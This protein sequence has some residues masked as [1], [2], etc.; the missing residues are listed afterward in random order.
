M[1]I[2][3]YLGCQA[4]HRYNCSPDYSRTIFA[5]DSLQ[6]E[7]AEYSRHTDGKLIRQLISHIS[8][9]HLLGGAI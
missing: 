4:V 6:G 7:K 1:T 3:V 8:R 9:R 2:V 5:E